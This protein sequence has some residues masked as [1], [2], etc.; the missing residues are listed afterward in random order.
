MSYTRATCEPHGVPTRR[1]ARRKERIS[2]PH[3]RAYDHHINTS[4]A[5]NRKHEIV[6]PWSDPDIVLVEGL[7]PARF[8]LIGW[9]DGNLP[10]GL[11]RET[12]PKS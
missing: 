7:R 2:T 10:P 3:S 5:I 1:W 11:M 12:M 8:A 9:A 4:D 6:S